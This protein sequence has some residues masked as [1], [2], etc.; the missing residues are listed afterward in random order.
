MEG[1]L[2]QVD[3]LTK[4]DWSAKEI[5]RILGVSK[6]TVECDRSRIRNEVIGRKPKVKSVVNVANITRAKQLFTSKPNMSKR[7]VAAIMKTEGVK[8]S[9][10]SALRCA[11]EAGIR[12]F[13]AKRKCYLRPQHMKKRLLYA[14]K[15]SHRQW[16]NALFVDECAIE[17][18]AAPNPQTHGQWAEYKEEVPIIPKFKHP[19]RLN[20]FGGISW[21]GRTKLVFYTETLNSQRYSDILDDVI[22]EV[23]DGVFKK[24]KWFIV[25][26]ALPLHFARSVH[27]VVKA[28]GVGWIEKKDWPANSPDLN[29]IE[30]IWSIL[31][32][33]IQERNPQTKAELMMCASEEWKNI[34]QAVI[35]KTILDMQKRLREVIHNKGSYTNK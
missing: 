11:K 12:K 3:K 28:H 19:I 13:S 25:Q 2:K 31:K 7:K 34:P 33:R 26:D 6:R 17:L 10:S 15:N 30:N 18:F 22:P 20:V 35:Q 29:P 23:R 27:N 9:A 21:S 14:Q 5:A 24:R 16:K 8:I 1:R 4:E 32:E